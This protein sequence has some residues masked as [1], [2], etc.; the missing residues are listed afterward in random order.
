[1]M[2]TR[3]VFA[4]FSNSLLVTVL[5]SILSDTFAKVQRNASQEFVRGHSPCSFFCT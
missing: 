3:V 1:M 4:L 2:T 5:I